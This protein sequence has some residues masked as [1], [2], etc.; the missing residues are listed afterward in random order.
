MNATPQPAS[1]PV[2]DVE[3][4]GPAVSGAGTIEDTEDENKKEEERVQQL[5]ELAAEPN[6]AEIAPVTPVRYVLEQGRVYAVL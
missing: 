5:A 3:G 6:P 1:P 4:H 2:K